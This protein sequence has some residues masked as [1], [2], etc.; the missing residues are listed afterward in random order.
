MLT[1]RSVV[2]APRL[3]PSDKCKAFRSWRR[4]ARGG[5]ASLALPLPAASRRWPCSF[6]FQPA[7]RSR[8]RGPHPPR[9]HM[10]SGTRGPPTPL[11]LAHAC[12]SLTPF[13]RFP[14][15]RCRVGHQPAAVADHQHFLQVR[16]ETAPAFERQQVLCVHHQ[17]LR[18]ACGW[19]AQTAGSGRVRACLPSGDAPRDLN[20]QPACCSTSQMLPSWLPLCSKPCLP[21]AHP[22]HPKPY[23]FCRKPALPK[24]MPPSPLT[25]LQQQGDLPA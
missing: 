20:L 2:F 8:F 23:R 12:S 16:P 24:P 9:R 6:A 1:A 7:P 15:P 3:D 21:A 13:P 19:P 4:R 5:G 25:G 10:H 22:S 17:R 11:Q 14:P 18:Q